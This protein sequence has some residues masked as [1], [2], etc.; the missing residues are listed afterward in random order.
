MSAPIN[1]EAVRE[2]VA[3][4]VA[5]TEAS[6]PVEYY[7]HPDNPRILVVDDER[8]IRDILSDFLKEEGYAVTTVE[9]G[10]AAM[11]ELHRASY[12]LVI[13]VEFSPAER[14]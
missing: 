8:V 5:S 9:D 4:K 12:N 13:S 7:L 6:P 14:T 1:R 2:A 10:V 3:E 11:E